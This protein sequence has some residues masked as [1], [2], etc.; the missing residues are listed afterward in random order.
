MVTPVDWGANVLAGG[1]TPPPCVACVS[2]QISFMPATLFTFA[3]LFTQ[4]NVTDPVLG[5]EFGVAETATGAAGAPEERLLDA[6]D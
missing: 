1:V 3:G 5:A 6:A 2:H 4:V